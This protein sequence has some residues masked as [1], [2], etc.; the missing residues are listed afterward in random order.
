MDRSNKET[1]YEEG[2]DRGKVE[3]FGFNQVIYRR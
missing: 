2:F 1:R 3:T